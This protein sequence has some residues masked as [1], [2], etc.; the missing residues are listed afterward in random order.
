[1]VNTIEAIDLFCGA[2]G[3]T[4]GLQNVGIKV[5]AGVD[6]DPNCRYPYEENNNSQYI[7]KSVENI[8]GA[9]LRKLYSKSSV[10]VLAGCAPCQP[11]SSYSQGKRGTQDDKWKLLRE[12]SR[13]VLE[14][15][16]HIVTMEN[17]PKLANH[18][19]FQEF[20][21]TLKRNK[22]QVTYQVVK[23]EK[24][25]LPQTRRRLVLMASRLG[26]IRLPP[27]PEDTCSETV[28]SAI[29]S[30]RHLHKIDAGTNASKDP[31]HRSAAL[32]ETNFKRIKCSKPGGTWRDW[33]ESLRAECHKAE[34]GRSY[35]S[36]YGRMVWDKP[37]PTITTQYY[38]FGNGRFGHPE[39]DRAISLREGAVLQ[40]FPRSYKFTPP[41]HPIGFKA[42]GLMVGNAVPPL[43]GRLIGR[44]I[45]EHAE[46]HF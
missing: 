34:S 36:V 21:K 11:F 4:F 29:G 30:C 24:Y 46:K 39:Q 31:L 8:Q 17:V 16:P 13:L 23:C 2:G 32:S 33:D 43:L 26:E 38:G 15:K 40:S 19:V 41:G 9:F 12:L 10:R 35:P 20:I 1:M 37:S 6:I 22:Y 7:D 3:L 18:S 5:L 25:G 27:A 44:S 45:T 28:R 42:I 14:S